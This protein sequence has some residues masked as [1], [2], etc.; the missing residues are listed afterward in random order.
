MM[1]KSIF[2]TIFCIGVLAL[3]GSCGNKRQAD[4]PQKKSVDDSAKIVIPVKDSTIYGRAGDC[5]MSTFCLIKDD[6]DTLYVCR[7]SES[8]VDGIIFGDLVLGDRF[9]MIA[10]DHN[11]SLVRAINLTQLELFVDKYKIFNGNIIL[12]GPDTEKGDTIKILNL[13]PDKFIYED[14]EGKKVVSR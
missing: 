9:C 6:G 2:W 10:G 14:M 4:N 1:G 3:S 11:T 8:G 12:S 7:T 13:S 5:G